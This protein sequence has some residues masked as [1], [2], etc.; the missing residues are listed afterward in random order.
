MGRAYSKAEDY[1]SAIQLF[2]IGSALGDPEAM[3]QQA[4]AYIVGEGAERNY[5]KARDL[6]STAMGLGHADSHFLMG[7]A[8]D[9]GAGVEPDLH[10]AFSLYMTAG[11]KGSALGLHRVAVSYLLGRGVARDL[12]KADQFA[13]R[14]AQAGSLDAQKLTSRVA[15]AKAAEN[16]GGPSIEETVAF[17]ESK[18]REFG[19]VSVNAKTSEAF[20]KSVRTNNKIAVK[21]GRIKVERF[22]HT[23]VDRRGSAYRAKL[24]Y[25]STTDTFSVSPYDLK[26]EAK[27]E[28]LA[29]DKCAVKLEC[30]T[31]K[32]VSHTKRERYSFDNERGDELESAAELVDGVSVFFQGDLACPRMSAAL[33]RLVRLYGGSDKKDPF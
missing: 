24:L 13:R 8:Y 18:T 17:I 22:I 15:I 33:A 27:E 1:S 14:S 30:E 5:A 11:E 6:L 12:D 3:Y 7:F 4:Q 9:I 20:P 19:D 25:T 28:N 23:Y 21:D 29:A 32:C 10:E 26:I 16:D 31:Q 2:R